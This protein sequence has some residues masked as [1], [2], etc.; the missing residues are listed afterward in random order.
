MNAQSNAKTKWLTT[1]SLVLG[2][3]S[4]EIFLFACLILLWLKQHSPVNEAGAWLFGGWAILLFLVSLILGIVTAFIAPFILPYDRH[5]STTPIAFVGIFISF[6]L[7]S[8]IPGLSALVIFLIMFR[9][10]RNAGRDNPI[11]EWMV[12]AGVVL[13]NFV[14]AIFLIRAAYLYG[15]WR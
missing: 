4:F 6:S 9:R 11:Q 5:G 1:T 12:I 14:L 2:I 10:N 8:L 7:L 15:F 13:G 3:L